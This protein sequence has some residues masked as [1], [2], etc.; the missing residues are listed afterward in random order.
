MLIMDIENKCIEKNFETGDI[1][2]VDD[3]TCLYNNKYYGLENGEQ[4]VLNK[5]YEIVNYDIELADE[6]EVLYT[7]K[8]VKTDV[9][10]SV[11]FNDWEIEKS[12]ENIYK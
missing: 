7:L 6:Y 2:V 8:D 12:R 9:I 1:V 11:M 4:V 10:C 3:P 5:P